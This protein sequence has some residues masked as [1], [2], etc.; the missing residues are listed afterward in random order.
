MSCRKSEKRKCGTHHT[1]QRLLRSVA[2][3]KSSTSLTRHPHRSVYLSVLFVRPSHW[4]V[5]CF[6]TRLSYFHCLSDMLPL[7]GLLC[8]DGEVAKGRAAESVRAAGIPRKEIQRPWSCVRLRSLARR[9]HL[10]VSCTDFVSRSC[11]F[12][13]FANFMPTVFFFFYLLFHRSCLPPPG[14]L[15]TLQSVESCPSVLCWALTERS[16]SMQH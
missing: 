4:S 1:E 7:H 10:E 9:C 16:R 3:P 6:W 12:W 13:L 5:Q 2:K 11:S 15:L 8:S 14:L